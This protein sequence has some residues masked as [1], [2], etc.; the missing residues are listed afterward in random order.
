MSQSDMHHAGHARRLSQVCTPRVG[1]AQIGWGLPRVDVWMD[2]LWSARDR[3][4]ASPRFRH[5]AAAF[6]LT[7]PIARRR[8]RDLFDLC[9]GFV[10][11]QVLL[12]CVRLR[13]FDILAQRSMTAHEVSRRLGMEDEAAERLLGELV[14]VDGLWFP[15]GID[16]NPTPGFREHYD[17]A[18][19]SVLPLAEAR[20]V[21]E[22]TERIRA[23]GFRD[24]R[25]RL[26]E[27]LWELDRD[28]GVV[29]GHDLVPQHLITARP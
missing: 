3:L 29:Q 1:L 17:P 28:R 16:A 23:A 10:Y 11:S 14:A 22:L 12:A 21:E 18:V 13:L 27:Q 5:W 7:R 6:P 2:R 4:M 9:A 19:R 26:L 24:V 8:S 15:R 20:S 25:V